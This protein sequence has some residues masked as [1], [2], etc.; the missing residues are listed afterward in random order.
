MSATRGRAESR[1]CSEEG[2]EVKGWRGAR[3]EIRGQRTRGDRVRLG[4]FM[5]DSWRPGKVNECN[6]IGTPR[7]SFFLPSL[8]SSFALLLVPLL[9]APPF[10][11]FTCGNRGIN[12]SPVTRTLIESGGSSSETRAAFFA[13]LVGSFT[14]ATV[15]TAFLPSNTGTPRHFLFVYR[16]LAYIF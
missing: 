2:G 14:Q 1:G 8:S 12:L 4:P 7:L 10:T 13:W 11:L 9:V 3:E 16:A 6:C 5:C 15:G